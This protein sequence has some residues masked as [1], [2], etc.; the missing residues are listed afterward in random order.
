ML[1]A[2]HQLAQPSTP[3]ALHLAVLCPGRAARGLLSAATGLQTTSKLA[4]AHGCKGMLHSSQNCLCPRGSKIRTLV[5]SSAS[6]SCVSLSSAPS[7]DS[8]RLSRA[9][10]SCLC[11]SCQCIDRG[12]R[13]SSHTSASGLEIMAISK[14]H[15][16]YLDSMCSALIK[17]SGQI[18][19]P[20]LGF[21]KAA[22]PARP[23]HPSAPSLEV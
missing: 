14:S 1:P 22:D 7:R 19:I 11:R 3:A 5:M 15:D 6:A 12:I 10:C 2:Q 20:R 23:L 13:S 17:M 9:A 8:A 16:F 18:C 4:H 21:W